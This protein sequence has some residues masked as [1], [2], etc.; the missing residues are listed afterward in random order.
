[1]NNL[2]ELITEIRLIL[3]IR[4]KLGQIATLVAIFYLHIGG[5][6]PI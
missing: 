4:K 3:N 6:D 5:F 2:K 1:M